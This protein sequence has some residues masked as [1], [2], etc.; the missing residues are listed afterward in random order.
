MHVIEYLF[1]HDT[2]IFF[3]RLLFQDLVVVFIL[4]VELPAA[5]AAMPSYFELKGRPNS[6]FLV[7]SCHMNFWFTSSK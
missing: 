3:I 4:E 6:G 7:W 5:P 2:R 1:Q